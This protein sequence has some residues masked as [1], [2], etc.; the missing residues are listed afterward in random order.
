MQAEILHQTT[1][2]RIS[3][4]TD[5]PKFGAISRRYRD[6]TITEK[7]DGTNG[8]ISIER[9]PFGSSIQ[10]WARMEADL[11]VVLGNDLAED[12]LPDHEFLVRAGSRN[13]WLSVGT[14]DN[15]GF[16]KWVEDN[17]ETLIADLGEGMHYGEWWGSKIGRGYG[18]TNGE[19]RFSLFNVGR[20]MDHDERLGP[21][22]PV[23]STPNLSGV[24]VLEWEKPNSD[25]VIQDVLAD[26]RKRGSFAQDG[27]MNPEGIVIWHTQGHFYEKVT[28]END[29][30][31][32]SKV[33]Q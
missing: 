9:A 32:K 25:E 6:I 7:I 10:R 5:Y 11:F 22:Y 31:P 1:K 18:L 12:G 8:L 28:L 4:M 23:F 13:R 16:A 33:N 3:E 17:A 26:L 29:E 27:F 14:H 21:Q 19:R 15:Y 30:L 24:P 2:R 20:W